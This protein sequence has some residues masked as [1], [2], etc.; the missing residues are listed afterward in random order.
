MDGA[1]RVAA[2]AAAAALLLAGCAATSTGAS[3]LT[4]THV[5]SAGGLLS[6]LADAA[7][8]TVEHDTRGRVGGR[9]AVDGTEVGRWHRDAGQDL[10]LEV[11][12]ARSAPMLGWPSASLTRALTALAAENEVAWEVD[13]RVVVLVDDL[14]ALVF[15]AGR[16]GLGHLAC[17]L[18]LESDVP[19]SCE[20]TTG[21][22][23]TRV[24]HR[25]GT[26]AF[27]RAP[28]AGDQLTTASGEPHLTVREVKAMADRFA[29]AASLEV[30]TFPPA[31]P[32]VDRTSRALELAEDP[33]AARD[34]EVVWTRPD[35]VRVVDI[36]DGQVCFDPGRDRPL[37]SC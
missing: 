30:M 23:D 34:G 9:I 11:F 7:V 14:D 1:R 22:A 19:D 37:G 28:M 16:A 2:A 5:A 18:A 26:V 8:V 27:D 4:S 13:D 17:T 36:G 35:G 6:P 29:Q 31:R 32:R 12:L 24:E 10:L 21:G 25:D 3:R 15:L 20:V 33:G